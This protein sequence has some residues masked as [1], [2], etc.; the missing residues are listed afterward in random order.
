MRAQLSSRD[1]KPPAMIVGKGMDGQTPPLGLDKAFRLGG[2]D[3]LGPGGI[4]HAIIHDHQPA[5]RAAIA[6]A[7]GACIEEDRG[8]FKCPPIVLIGRNTGRGHAARFL[9][10]VAQLPHAVLSEVELLNCA[11]E[12]QQGPLGDNL[13][14]SP[15]T[16]A[17]AV[18]RCAN[19]IVTIKEADRLSS[20][21]SA[22]MLAMVDPA[23]GQAWP[24]ERLR[25]WVDLS[26]VNWILRVEDPAKLP[27][28][29]LRHAF[30][31][32]M[33]P[34]AWGAN[35]FLQLSVTLEVLNDMGLRPTAAAQDSWAAL[36]RGLRDPGDLYVAIRRA[37]TDAR[38]VYAPSAGGQPQEQTG[39]LK[40]N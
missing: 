8:W 31:V 12:A 29:L 6:A 10:Q 14:V 11:T 38:G 18:S 4:P 27:H 37:L 16:L 35:D 7:C 30:V 24:E 13:W 39:H 26:E 40:G 22:T 9:S 15:V 1:S 19:P 5:F 21:A 3:R 23:A 20:A 25:T 36:G 2:G 28:S 34:S 32:E 33:A 17:M